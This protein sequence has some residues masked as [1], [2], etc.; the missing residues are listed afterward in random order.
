VFR[1]RSSG[2]PADDPAPPTTSSQARQPSKGRPTPKR[3]EAERRR[4]QP[5]AAQP[6]DRK[7]ASAKRRADYQR[8]RAAARRGEDWALK[9]VHRG[10]VRALARDYVDSRRLVLSQYILIAVIVAV[11]AILFL[12]LV[13][14]SAPILYGEL[15]VVGVITAEGLFHSRR[16]IKLARDRFPGESTRGLGWYVT[17]RVTQPR[18]ARDP[19]PRVERGASI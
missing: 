13:S 19:Q 14:S 2:T 7:A 1:Q 10:P 18:M 12:R 16:V 11:V 3:S 8:N 4:R 5:I 9:P 17:R 15:A 6:A